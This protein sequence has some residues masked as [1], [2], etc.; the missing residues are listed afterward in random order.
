MQ[1]NQRKKIEISFLNPE[2]K[3][4]A[5]RNKGLVIFGIILFAV[6]LFASFYQVTRHVLVGNFVDGTETI[7][8]LKN[9]GIVLI[10]AGIIF[11]ALG[12]LYRP[13]KTLLP[14]ERNL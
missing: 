6:G 2:G 8:P 14:Q 4:M 10:V 12:F 13:R 11:L 1:L 3:S 9:V 7:T 5:R